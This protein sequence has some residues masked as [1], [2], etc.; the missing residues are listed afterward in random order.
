MEGQSFRILSLLF[1]FCIFFLTISL[2]G[3]KSKEI[4]PDNPPTDMVYV[5]GGTYKMGDIWGVKNKL[6]F[7]D[8]HPTHKVKVKSFYMSKYEVTVKDYIEFLNNREIS[9][10]DE[11]NYHKYGNELIFLE[12]KQCPIDYNGTSFYF[13]GSNLAPDKKCPVTNVT[14]FG[15][16]EYCNWK[17]KR[18]GLTQVY[19]N[20]RGDYKIN[21]DFNANGY[22]LPTEAEWEYAA[23]SEGRND[24]KWSGTNK[25]TELKEYAWYNVSRTHE[26]G[27]KKPND[28]GI[29][30]MSGN[31]FEWC[32]DLYGSNYYSN[33]PTN[34]PR[35][36]K[37]VY[38]K[39]VH[40]I[41]TVRIFRTL[42]GGRY[43]F[44]ANWCRTANRW[45]MDPI[46]SNDYGFRTVRTD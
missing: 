27:T 43:N 21:C 23:R 40:D 14:W 13:T 1:I 20:I 2:E 30:D 15:A 6:E 12:S 7:E 11:Y 39:R 8:E 29:Y 36:R 41:V 26:V 4:N 9:S 28:I 17:S 5:K 3:Q 22:R 37:S 46:S 24:R 19:D 25:K 18:E 38:I 31:V 33:S 34:N 10:D 32:W 16:V 45:F 42:R 35:D 44:N